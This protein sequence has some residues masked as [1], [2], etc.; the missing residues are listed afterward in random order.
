MNSRIFALVD[1][2]N[3][4]ASCERV[5]NPKLE[6][7]PIVV[8]S[9]NDG[10]IVSRS[11]EAKELKIPMGAPYFKYKELINK[12]GVHV[13]SSNYTFYGDMSRRVMESLRMLLP[14][15]EIY[16]IDEA[17][18]DLSQYRESNLVEIGE[19]IKEKVKQWTGI[20]ISIGIAHTKTLSKVA[21]SIAK[22][23]K[24]SSICDLRKIEKIE[25]ELT[26]LD[27]EEIWGIA[28]GWGKRLKSIGIN[29]GYDLMK[30]N[31]EYIR[32][33]I[34]VVGQRIIMEL[35]GYSCIDIERV[36]KKKSI[37]SSK[38]FGYKV[39]EIQEIKEAVSTYAARACEK[40]RDQKSRVQVISVYLRTSPFEKEDSRYTKSETKV[41]S[42]PTSSTAKV[43]T[44]AN[45]IIEEIYREGYRYQKTGITLLNL[46]NE[47]YVQESLYED[48]SL[49]GEE[50]ITT[51]MD[52][53][54]MQ[55]GTNTIFHASQGTKKDW[56]VKSDSRSKKYTTS[57]KELPLVK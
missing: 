46:I 6:N 23:E 31:P 51:V 22:K 43:I 3:F 19:E 55:Y 30:A 44:A 16:S 49:E 21:N 56:R 52:Q 37:I 48:G 39:T 41:L 32:Q 14:D 34:S 40:L 9:N 29:T 53:V 5:F 45:K 8:L 28:S 13:F 7:E 18:V 54:N 35:N 36:Q 50:K 10:C 27:V 33:K 1:C 11:N 12:N 24:E 42:A 2:N 17:F 15:L 26:I 57:L 38:S 4:Y 20:P 25:E 47:D